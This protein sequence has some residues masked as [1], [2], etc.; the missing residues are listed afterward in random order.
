MAI[1]NISSK[2]QGGKLV[3]AAD[4]NYDT[5]TLIIIALAPE[6]VDDRL[7]AK[8]KS[9]PYTVKITDKGTIVARGT[10]VADVKTLLTD[11]AAAANNLD[12][13]NEA[14]LMIAMNSMSAASNSLTQKLSAELSSGNTASLDLVSSMLADGEIDAENIRPILNKVADITQFNA[15]NSNSDSLRQSAQQLRTY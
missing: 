12:L 8:A 13:A 7:Y 10:P 1:N 5:A 3:V 4:E 15:E 6:E 11:Y 9:L 2:L 14:A